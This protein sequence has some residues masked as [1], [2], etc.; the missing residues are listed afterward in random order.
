V[1]TGLRGLNT[2]KLSSNDFTSLPILPF[3]TSDSS[4]ATSVEVFCKGLLTSPGNDN[5]LSEDTPV[6][7]T[8]LFTVLVILSE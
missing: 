6:P 4:L 1:I 8:E 3:S 2:W 5:L 7:G